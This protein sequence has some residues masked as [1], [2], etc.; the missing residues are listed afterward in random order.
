M[1]DARGFMVAAYVLTTLT[2]AVYGMRLAARARA[3]HR[4]LNAARTLY[5]GTHE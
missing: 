4:R 2:I 3:A 1:P 5:G